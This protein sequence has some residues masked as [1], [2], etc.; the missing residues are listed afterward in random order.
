MEMAWL[1][2]CRKIVA[3]MALESACSN[4]LASLLYPDASFVKWWVI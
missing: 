2:P 4:S 1:I 3:P